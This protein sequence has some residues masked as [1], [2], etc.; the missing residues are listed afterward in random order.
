MCDAL[1]KK[2]EILIAVWFKLGKQPGLIHVGEARVKRDGLLER[3]RV[4]HRNRVRYLKVR[5]FVAAI[6]GHLITEAAAETT[7][8]SRSL[9]QQSKKVRVKEKNSPVPEF[10]DPV[11]RK[12][13]Q[14]ARF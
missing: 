2:L 7:G 6:R 8:S 11:S 12:Q 14:N 13:A 9:I 4:R 10:I 1:L 3:S 5:N